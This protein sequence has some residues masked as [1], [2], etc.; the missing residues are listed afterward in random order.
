[1]STYPILKA[2]D[3]H[4]RV[5]WPTVLVSLGVPKEFLR[6][7]RPG[8]CLFCG[9]QDRWVFDNRRGRGDYLCRRC[10]AGDGFTLLQKFFK[11]DFSSVRKRVLKAAGLA[12]ADCR[13]QAPI[14]HG[15][16]AARET[17]RPSQPTRRALEIL[18]SSTT[19]EDCQDVRMYL[20]SRS[21]WP[22]PEKC[23]LRAHPSIS[24]FEKAR[25]IGRYAAL[26]APVRDISGRLVTTHITYLQ[27]GLKF[28]G[29]E[30]RKFVSKMTGRK[31]CAVRLS[32]MRG[33]TL[34]IAEGIESALAAAKMHSLPVWSALTASLLAK[35]DPPDTVKDLVIYA[36]NDEP[37]RHAASRLLERL[38]RRIRVEIVAPQGVKD[39]N[40]V[41]MERAN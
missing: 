27:G 39:W 6:I 24:Y 5:E 10:G 19:V 15:A 37:G 34:G 17:G 23:E 31:G 14:S 29:H 22:L 21:L 33:D 30:P 32:P 2:A 4:A 16:E 35:F 8:P 9:G 12:D 11:E 36:D 28:Q 1:M 25:Y 26:V 3:I 20:D 40:N 13:G 7:K 38:Q 41:I 18:R